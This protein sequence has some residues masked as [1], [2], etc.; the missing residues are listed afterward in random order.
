MS[1]ARRGQTQ[2]P[3]YIAKIKATKTTKQEA[4]LAQQQV[5][6]LPLF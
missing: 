6:Q 3:E 1:A 4:N 2:S 5:K